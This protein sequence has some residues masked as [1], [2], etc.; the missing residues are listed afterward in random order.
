MRQIRVWT[1]LLAGAA[2]VIVGTATAALAG[3][4]SSPTGVKTW[5][6]AAW[7]LSLGIFGTHIAVERRRQ[8]RAV[9]VATSVALAV[10]LGAFVVA[11][12]GPFRAHWG[13]PSR[14]R[15]A[16]LSLVAWPL[17]TGIPAFG[18]ALVVGVVLDRTPGIS[19]PAATT[20]ND[21]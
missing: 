5:R 16:M 18:V 7:L 8:L 6:L 17:L 4:A 1:V 2:Y 19:R 13:D 9:S 11:A 15:L 20:S 3:M 21:S 10:A 14:L 12:L